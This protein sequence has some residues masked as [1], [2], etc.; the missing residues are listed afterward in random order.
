MT[1]DWQPIETAP[2]VMSG[3][4]YLGWCPGHGGVC[5]I[6]WIEDGYLSGPGDHWISGGAIQVEPTH[7]M[8]LPNPPEDAET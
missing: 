6:S 5:F 4:R 2:K 7:W 3:T 8:P 1:C